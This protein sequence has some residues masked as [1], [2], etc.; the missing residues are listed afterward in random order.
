VFAS[1]AVEAAY[2][3]GGEWLDELLSYLQ[4]NI[5]YLRSYLGEDLPQVKLIEPEGTF[6]AWLDFRE[7]GL[8]AKALA[9]FLAQKAEVA[10]NPGHWFGREGAGYARMNIACP[11]SMLREGLL[12]LTDA[13]RNRL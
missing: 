11:Q 9:Q 10:L 3:Q 5:D 4:A 6:L 7:L 2:S 13:V 12:R 8:D 1:A